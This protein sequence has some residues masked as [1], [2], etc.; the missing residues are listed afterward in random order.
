MNV[1]PFASPRA[2]YADSSYFQTDLHRD[3]GQIVVPFE[4][5]HK[6]ITDYVTVVLSK[7]EKTGTK[8]PPVAYKVYLNFTAN[9]DDGRQA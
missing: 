2:D 6:P 7:W 4:A 9:Y 3:R 1:E 8:S 5:A